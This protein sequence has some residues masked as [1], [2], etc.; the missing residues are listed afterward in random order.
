[1]T[2]E[3]IY[4]D[5]EKDFS[6]QEEPS[7]QEGFQ[8]SKQD[9]TYEKKSEYTLNLQDQKELFDDEEENSFQDSSEKDLVELLDVHDVHENE[10]FLAQDE[11]GEQS[12]DQNREGKTLESSET[13]SASDDLNE[14]YSEL[15]ESNEDSINKTMTY[16]NKN[17]DLDSQ[18]DETREANKEKIS[19]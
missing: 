9:G 4:G 12:S 5:K 3:I 6:K 18:A 2:E 11:D 16:M 13:S 1:M 8:F 19:P 10:D 15:D 7:Q 17:E 14:V